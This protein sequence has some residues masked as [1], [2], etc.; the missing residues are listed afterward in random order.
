[1][2]I[3]HR[4]VLTGDGWGW[5]PLIP[6]LYFFLHHHMV[7]A[8]KT[9]EAAHLSCLFSHLVNTET[10]LGSFICSMTWQEVRLNRCFLVSKNYDCLITPMF[11]LSIKG[12][13]F[14][15][16]LQQIHVLLSREHC[17]AIFLPEPQIL[18]FRFLGSYWLWGRSIAS[19]W[20]L[21]VLLPGAR[22]HSSRWYSRHR[23]YAWE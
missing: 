13:H 2:P 23:V 15:E 12:W 18:C 19:G 17:V 21:L 9:W 22:R 1:M 20:W 16:Q 5:L 3:F 11:P 6:L 7:G 10:G 8:V 14:S 4:N